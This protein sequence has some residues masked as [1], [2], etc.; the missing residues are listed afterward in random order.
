MVMWDP[1]FVGRPLRVT[2]EA[3]APDGDR[4]KRNERVPLPGEAMDDVAARR[5][6][7]GV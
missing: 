1:G 6:E 4:A 5:V 7:E 2:I 3:I